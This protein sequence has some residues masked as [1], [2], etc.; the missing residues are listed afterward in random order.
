M[1]SLIY[2]GSSWPKNGEGGEA[3]TSERSKLIALCLKQTHHTRT[4][5]APPSDQASQLAV[6]DPAEAGGGEESS[7]LPLFS[8]LPV[9]R[10]GT[11]SYSTA[12]EPCYEANVPNTHDDILNVCILHDCPLTD[13]E[14]VP[15]DIPCRKEF[16]LYWEEI[17]SCWEESVL[18]WEESVLYWEEFCLCWEESVLYWEEFWLY[19]EEICLCWEESVLYWEEICLC[20]EESVLYWEEFWVALEGVLFAPVRV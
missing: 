4:P 8:F 11:D 16:W 6:E 5:L 7:F 15:S 19:W 14:H 1:Q 10:E 13:R 17:C 12:T 20:W 3:R 18:C 2:K 9:Q